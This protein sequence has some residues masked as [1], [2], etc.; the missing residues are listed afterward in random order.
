MSDHGRSRFL[1]SFV[2]ASLCHNV[3]YFFVCF[4]SCRNH[5]TVGVDPHP[6]GLASFYRIRID[7][8]ERLVKVDLILLE[9]NLLTISL[10]N[11]LNIWVPVFTFSVRS[12]SLVI[13]FMICLA[14]L[15]FL[16]GSGDR[17]LNKNVVGY[18]EKKTFLL[19]ERNS[20]CDWS[21]LSPA[22]TPGC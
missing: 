16:F 1:F 13:L 15:Q 17:K 5:R 10:P 20:G 6:Y 21:E 18:F 2:L 12:E 3:F 14:L 9:R 22:E 11:S 19:S 8:H 4:C 7:T